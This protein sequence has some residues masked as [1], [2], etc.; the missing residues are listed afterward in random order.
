MGAAVRGKSAELLAPLRVPAV[1]RLWLAQLISAVGDWSARLA[2]ALL[3]LDRTHSAAAVGLVTAASLLGWFGPGQLLAT[4]ADRWPRRRVMIVAD[5]IRAAA[6]AV[7]AAPLPLPVLVAVVAVAGCATPPFEGARAALRPVLTPPAL[8]GAA[9]TVMQLTG[10]TA[11]LGGYLTGG[12]LVTAVGPAVALLA[13]AGS[14]LVSALLA[15]ALPRTE[16]VRDLLDRRLRAAARVLTGSPPLRRAIGLTLLTQGAAAGIDALAAPYAVQVAH[17]GAARAALLA[18]VAGGAS[19]ALTALIPLGGTTRQLLTRCAWL[20]TVP[21]A[22]VIALFAAAPPL[23]GFLAFAAAG[24]LMVTLVPANT[25][26]GPQLP[27]AVR[28]GAFS[29]LGGATVALQGGGAAV[30]GL[31]TGLAGIPAAA[32]L[33][34]VP[35][36]AAGMWALARP[37]PSGPDG[38]AA[39]VPTAAAVPS[40]VAGVAGLA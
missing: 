6:F 38:T 1:R 4:V 37:L 17:A 40:A 27:D 24:T 33:V 22:V 13:N 23:G 14:F 28:A 3:V 31:L 21:A 9:V 32:A 16:Q 5:L 26:V 2:L 35:A 20:T 8:F 19:L 39:P 11:M 10:D 30:A 25:L 15:A 12:L 36:L 34:A 7:A 18:A 29:L